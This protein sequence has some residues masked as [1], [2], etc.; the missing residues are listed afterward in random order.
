M[1]CLWIGQ[2]LD[3]ISGLSKSTWCSAS[4]TWR[5]IAELRSSFCSLLVVFRVPL[6][7]P[8]TFLHSVSHWSQI[9]QKNGVQSTFNKRKY[10]YHCEYV[11][12]LAC[13][14]NE[15]EASWR[16]GQPRSR[17][18]W[19]PSPDRASSAT[20]VGERTGWKCLASLHKTVE[21]GD[22][23]DAIGECSRWMLTQVQVSK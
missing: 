20:H 22:V 8:R 6:G 17:P 15:L 9:S 19:N 13:G 16:R 14:A 7:E 3:R 12:R 4:R 10:F 21:P 18:T 5:A 2:F 23:I 1:R 11:S